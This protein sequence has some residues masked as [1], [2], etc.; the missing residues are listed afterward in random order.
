MSKEAKTETVVPEEYLIDFTK[1]PDKVEETPDPEEQPNPED[2]LPEKYKGKT[3]AEIVEMH[4]NAE[5]ELGRARNEIGTVR[6]LAD[7]LLGI[8]VEAAQLTK[9]QSP[10]R[11]PL[12]T[13]ALLNDPEGS[14]LGL[15]KHD[16][17][18]REKASEDRVARLE[19]ELAM[20]KFERKHPGFQDTMQDPKFVDW[21]QKSPYRARLAQGAIQGDFSAADELFTL[22]GEYQPPAKESD[23]TVEQPDPQAAARKVSLA[24]PGAASASGLAPGSTSGKQIWSRAKLMEMRISNPDEFE[25]LQP[26][27]L[28]AYA[29]RRVR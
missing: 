15:V 11:K 9:D 3:L 28:K 6:K 2:N 8:R 22:F 17:E 23:G 14:V 18:A 5:S 26:E 12:T 19:Y 29:E 20:T 1:G 21:V 13:D 27:I 7:Q 16:A 24:R 4:R 10:P 25:R